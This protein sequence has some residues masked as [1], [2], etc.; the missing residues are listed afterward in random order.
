MTKRNN[1]ERLGLPST[2]AKDTVDASAAAVAAPSGGGLS[3]VSPTA[4]VD[5]PSE[6][7]YYPE[8]HPLHNQLSLEIKEM[9]T[10]EEDI[11][12]S[13]SLIQKGVVFDKLLQNIIVDPRISPQHLLVGDKN[14]LLVSARVSGYGEIYETKVNCPSCYVSQAVS[15][16]LLNANVKGPVDLSE[17]SENVNSPVSE[18]GDLT[19]SVRLPKSQ[20]DAE[21]K[22]I[23]GQDERK[24]T[25]NRAMRKKRKMSEN[26]LTEHLRA[27]IVSVAGTADRQEMDGFIDRM[28]AQDS[29]FIRK[30]MNEITPNIDLTQE[31]VCDECDYEQDLEVPINAEFFWPDQ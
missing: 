14:A 25:A 2:G 15:F 9:T 10:K 26:I 23:N 17:A 28:P 13:K 8:G 24:I 11:L 12:T 20:L 21:L 29:R 1:E 5:L 22:L 18:T 6:G 3:F 7:R 31:F 27:C 4:M 16:N 19:F 30:V